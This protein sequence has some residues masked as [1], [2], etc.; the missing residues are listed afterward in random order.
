MKETMSEPRSDTTVERE[1]WFYLGTFLQGEMGDRYRKPG[2]RSPKCG[3]FVRRF[4]L[5]R[6]ASG[7]VRTAIDRDYV[8]FPD[9]DAMLGWI[10][11]RDAVEL[12]PEA[13]GNPMYVPEG[14]LESESDA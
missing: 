14:F 6:G 8:E 9:E 4:Q 1:G 13:D 3:L 11:E 12:P 10:E 7:K 2:E 5:R